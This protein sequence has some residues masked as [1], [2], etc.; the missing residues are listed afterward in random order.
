MDL[1]QLDM[2]A[3]RPDW[4]TIPRYMPHR[5]NKLDYLEFLTPDGFPTG[6]Y[7][8]LVESLDTSGPAWRSISK[9]QR[10]V[11]LPHVKY[12]WDARVMVVP[13]KNHRLPR[14][15]ARLNRA[16]VYQIPNVRGNDVYDMRQLSMVRPSG[17]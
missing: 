1:V 15:I 13:R 9:L 2:P 5:L 4:Y 8:V 10:H 14:F 3:T 16:G 6:E 17:R 7:D 12:G 11:E